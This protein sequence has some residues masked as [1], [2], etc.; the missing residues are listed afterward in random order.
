MSTNKKK[1]ITSFLQFMNRVR[2]DRMETWSPDLNKINKIDLHILLLV[3]ENP[4]YTIGD[5][6]NRLD[7]PASTLTSVINRMEKKKLIQRNITSDKRSYKL[8]LLPEGR[9][10]REAHDKLLIE[11][12]SQ[13][14]SAL[15]EDE[16]NTFIMLLQK[17]SANLPE[18]G[19]LSGDKIV[20]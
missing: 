2:A 3:Q 20:Q 12:A 18:T 15:S 6:K 5:I 16:Q 10:I 14:M 11:L 17:V 7:I 8:E 19:T 4:D 1:M 9:R 13:M